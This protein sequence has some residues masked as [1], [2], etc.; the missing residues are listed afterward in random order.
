MAAG[1][2]AGMNLKIIGAALIVLGCGSWGFGIASNHLRKISTI[3]I[4]NFNIGVHPCL[5]FADKQVSG[6]LEE[7]GRFL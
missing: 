5:Y 4:V 2:D 7:L 1:K 6:N 3:C